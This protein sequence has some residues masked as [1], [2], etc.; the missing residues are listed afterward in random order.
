LQKAWAIPGDREKTLK[1]NK[2][3][4]S[5]PREREKKTRRHRG[6]DLTIGFVG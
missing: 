5:Y 1:K 3:A 2:K 4:K 6:S